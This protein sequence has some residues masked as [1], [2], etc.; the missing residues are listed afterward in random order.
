MNYGADEASASTTFKIVSGLV[1]G[2]AEANYDALEGENPFRT[3]NQRKTAVVRGL[4]DKLPPE[5]I[6]LAGADFVGQVERDAE[7]VAVRGQQPQVQHHDAQ[8]AERD[9]DLEPA[10]EQRQ[11][12]SRATRLRC[13]TPVPHRAELKNRHIKKDMGQ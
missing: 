9:A 13:E 10:M 5:T 1:P 12:S 3:K 11:S 6:A 4:L 7:H 8:L 2:S